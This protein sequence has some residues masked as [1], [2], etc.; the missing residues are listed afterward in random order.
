[1]VLFRSPEGQEIMKGWL[2]TMD[3][4]SKAQMY[5]DYR[6]ALKET[7]ETLYYCDNCVEIENEIKK[8]KKQLEELERRW[9]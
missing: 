7:Y 4:R 8:L 6:I 5:K 9:E 3:G 1:V 2:K